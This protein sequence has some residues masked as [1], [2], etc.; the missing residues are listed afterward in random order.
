MRLSEVYMLS[1]TCLVLASSVT[2]FYLSTSFRNFFVTCT[3]KEPVP[4]N[5]KNVP[6]VKTSGKLKLPRL[7]Y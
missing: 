1:C 2:V 5:H 3:I 4:L 6:A 7:H